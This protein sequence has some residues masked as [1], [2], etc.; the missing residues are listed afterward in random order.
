ME[1]NIENI[2]IRQVQSELSSIGLKDIVEDC[3]R[4]IAT[5]TIKKL[6]ER[7]IDEKATEIISQEIDKQ[8]AGE[9]VI[10]D[11]WSKVTRFDNFEAMF[12][13]KMKEKM[14]AQYKVQ[15]LVRKKVSERLDMLITKEWSKVVERIVD[16]ITHSKLVKKP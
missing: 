3:L 12:R 7:I 14:E 5:E 15:D 10:N 16:E 4:Q 13:S 2:V 9:I 6:A 8:M 11:G 1:M